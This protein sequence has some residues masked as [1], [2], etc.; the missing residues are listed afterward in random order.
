MIRGIRYL[1]PGLLML[2]QACAPLTLAPVPDGLTQQ[3][4]ADW[5]QRVQTL[6]RFSHWQLSG[7]LAVRQ[8]DDSGSALINRWR[9]Q[10]DRYE[11]A[12]S[13]S[14]LGM[15]N[16]YLQGDT[17]FMELTLPNGDRYHSA[18]PEALVT[19]ATGWQLPLSELAWWV[20]G[21][22]APGGGVR[23]L[24]NTAGQPALLYQ[25]GWE[26]RYERWQ[27]FVSGLP[28]LPAR[29]TAVKDDRQVRLVITGW[30]A[31]EPQP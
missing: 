19:T 16:T 25:S 27:P 6:H 22:P 15:G 10:G 29:I 3:V 26:V 13:S 2:L 18:D 30:Q 28:E 24:F 7:K 23:L 11:V 14:F 5:P 4:P 9:Q 21:L 8:P 17:G 31:L 1:L 12:L 20:R